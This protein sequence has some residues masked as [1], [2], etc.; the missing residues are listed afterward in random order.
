MR[1]VGF[2]AAFVIGF[3]CFAAA[4][5]TPTSELL[6][7]CDRAAASPF[8]KGRPAGVAGVANEKIEPETAIQ[9][10]EAAAKAAPSDDRIAMQL[11]RGYLAAKNYDAARM[12]F[13]R[14]NRMGNALAAIQLA[15]F[16]E[17]GLGGLPADDVEALRLYKQAADGGLSLGQLSVGYFYQ[18]GRGALARDENEAARLYKKAADQGYDLAQNDLGTLYQKGSRRTSPG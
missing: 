5:E 15:I 8:D 11:G 4:A 1:L 13:D 16:Y 6:A 14:A 12:Q 17:R 18:F 9:A 10:C 7:A 2:T 3:S